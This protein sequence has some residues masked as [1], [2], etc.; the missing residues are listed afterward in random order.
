M[1]PGKK[2][3]RPS[4]A[5]IAVGTALVVIAGTMLAGWL[6][7]SRY[8][9]NARVDIA[10]P[11]AA[12]AGS[13]PPA[14]V[15]PTS[16]PDGEVARLATR[17]REATGLLMGLALL[18]LTEQ[19]NNRNLANVDA[20][21]ERMAERGLLP[22]GVERTTQNGAFVSAHASL[23]VRFRPLPLG[24]E[25]VSLGRDPLDGPA[26]IA[27]LAATGDEQ[28]GAILLVAKKRDSAP[29][30]RAFAPLAEVATLNWN[31]EPL[32]E[33]SFTPEEAGQ[34]NQWARQYAATGQ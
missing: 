8:R 34:L 13:T 32:R 4:P 6:N 9:V 12:M 20:L 11:I 10:D 16:L 19:M 3:W 18:A 21:I 33:R 24:V 26:V 25:V 15:N 17:I 23:H 7:A 31:I 14:S 1:K 2:S 27:R 30:P 28:S 22:P 5:I 29:M